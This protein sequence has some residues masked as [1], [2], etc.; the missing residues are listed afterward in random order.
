MNNLLNEWYFY[1]VALQEEQGFGN[2]VVIDHFVVAART[3]EEASTT[4][5]EIAQWFIWVTPDSWRVPDEVASKFSPNWPGEVTPSVLEEIAAAVQE[6]PQRGFGTNVMNARGR[7]FRVKYVRPHITRAASIGFILAASLT[8]TVLG[9]I[10][11]LIW[12]CLRW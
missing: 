4:A 8:L 1:Q 9:A 2:I 10:A 11:A 7:S 12:R 6:T 5:S 3:F